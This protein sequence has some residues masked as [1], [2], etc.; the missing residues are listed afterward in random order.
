VLFDGKQRDAVRSMFGAQARLRADKEIRQAETQRYLEARYEPDAILS[1]CIASTQPHPLTTP[2][3]HRS[4]LVV[5]KLRAVKTRTRLY[6]AAC[7]VF[8]AGAALFLFLVNR[9]PLAATAAA[10]AVCEVFA[11]VLIIAGWIRGE[12]WRLRVVTESE[13]Q[14]KIEPRATVLA[15][16]L[17]Q[18]YARCH[19]E[20]K[21]RR[22][23]EKAERRRRREER[24]EVGPGGLQ[25]LESVLPILTPY[26]DTWQAAPLASPASRGGLRAGK[27]R[28]ERSHGP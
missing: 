27:G 2:Q 8:L 21:A 20:E 23:A 22:A 1:S 26:D 16:E 25:P 10:L 6:S 12:R 3:P 9:S 7:L 28:G 11:L 13:L 5:N 4:Q 19:A 15:R 17:R 24:E 14:V 18:Q